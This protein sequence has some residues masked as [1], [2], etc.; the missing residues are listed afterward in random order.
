MNRI[1]CFFA[2][3]ESYSLPADEIAGKHE[4]YQTAPYTI[5][6]PLLL[7]SKEAVTI[8]Q[9][10]RRLVTL[11]DIH[12]LWDHQIKEGCLYLSFFFSHDSRKFY[13]TLRCRNMTPNILL[14]LLLFAALKFCDAVQASPTS[15]SCSRGSS[16]MCEV[17]QPE[18]ELT[19]SVS[20]RSEAWVSWNRAGVEGVKEGKLKFREEVI[21]F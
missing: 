12:V 8:L 6:L 1:K 19:G 5:P 17:N 11:P 9:F 20:R 3:N 15:S 14:R 16:M 7:S 18:N 2:V 10:I 13:T 4:T 21:N